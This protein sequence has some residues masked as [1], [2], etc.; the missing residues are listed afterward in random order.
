MAIDGKLRDDMRPSARIVLK[1]ALWGGKGK[2]W[3]TSVFFSVARAGR[4]LMVAA[5]SR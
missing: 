4:Y 2:R 1:R 3:F 5:H